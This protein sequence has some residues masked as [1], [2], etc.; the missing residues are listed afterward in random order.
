MYSVASATATITQHDCLSTLQLTARHAAVTEYSAQLHVLHRSR[1][2]IM[3]S[4]ICEW[5]WSRSLLVGNLFFVQIGGLGLPPFFLVEWP[6]SRHL[7]RLAPTAVRPMRR[8]VTASLHQPKH[9]WVS[10]F[11][12][13]TFSFMLLDG[14]AKGKV[15]ALKTTCMTLAKRY[16]QRSAKQY[17]KKSAR[18][19][20]SYLLGSTR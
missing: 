10:T 4:E 17:W 6:S 11:M 14:H 20:W 8:L 7:P 5:C 16:G 2:A 19:E 1:F 3:R 12:A 9:A 13:R 18:C 15:T